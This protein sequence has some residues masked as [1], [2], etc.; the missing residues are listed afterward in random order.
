MFELSFHVPYYA[1]RNSHNSDHR[2]DRHT[3]LRAVEDVPFLSWNRAGKSFLHEAHVSCV[4]AGTDERRYVGYCFVDTYFDRGGQTRESVREYEAD[5][6]AVTV[7]AGRVLHVDPFTLGN[8]FADPP[9]EDPRAY[10]LTV[11][12]YRISQVTC[13]W[14]KVVSM[15][16][17]SIREYE[18][19]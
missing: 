1:L 14:Q 12:R 10:F 3:P 13:E 5:S 18:Q 9:I 2:K 15:V 17:K 11:F 6:E 7:Q 16:K 8:T 19:V 4:V